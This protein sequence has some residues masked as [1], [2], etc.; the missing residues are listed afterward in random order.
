MLQV[1]FLP[2][3]CLYKI[4]AATKSS[5]DFLLFILDRLRFPFFLLKVTLQIRLVPLL[6]EHSTSNMATVLSYLASY[7]LNMLAEMTKEE[8]TLLFG[9][10]G[11]MDKMSIKL[12]DLK[13]FLADADRRNI[14]DFSVQEWVRELKGALFDATDILDLCQLKAME[15]GKHMDAGCFN[16]L[17][18]C[19]RNPLFAHDICSRIKKLN[20]RLDDIKESSAAF[21]FNL[22]S[23]EDHSRNNTS[24]RSSNRETS[25][26]VNESALVGEKIEEDTRSL[27][28][29]LT[30]DE[31]TTRAHNKIMVFAIVGVGGIGKTTLAQKIF[32][33]YKI[34]HEF[35]KKVWLSVNQDFNATELLKK[36][37]TEAGGDYQA[38]GNTRAALERTLKNAL[39]GHKTLLVVDDVWDHKAW[40]DVLE[41]PLAH[42]LAPGSRVLVTTR[43]YMVARGMNAVEVHRI[44]K[45]KDEDA[46]L[47]LKK[48]VVRNVND[49][50][51]VDMLKD[52][53][54][55]IIEKCDGLPL[56]VKVMGGHLLK[57]NRRRS[58]WEAVLKDLVWSVSQMPEKLYNAIY[59]SYQDLD[60]PLK[61][62]FLYFSL[63]PKSEDFDVDEI[64]GMWISEGIVHGN[65][66]D[67]EKIGRE[68]YDELILRNL[69][70][71][72]TNYADQLVCSMHDVVRSFAQYVARYEA[73]VAGQSSKIDITSKLNAQ[74]FIWLSLENKGSESLEW[75]SLQEQISARTLISVGN[76]IKIKPSDSLVTFSSLRTLHVQDADFDQ[77]S[78]SLVKLKHLRYLSIQY[79]NTSKLPEDIHKM[80]LLQ[81]IDISCCKRLVKLPSSIRKLQNLRYLNLRQSSINS[82]PRGFGGLTSLRILGGFPVHMD[83][84]W[85]SLEELGPLSKLI[86]LSIH[87]LENVSSST[88]ARKTNLGQKVHLRKLMLLCTSKHGNSDEVQKK[89]KQVYDELCPPPSLENLIIDGYFGRLLPRWMTSNAMLSLGS[90]RLLTLE[91]L[92][93]CIELPDVLCQLPCL[94]FLRIIKAPA[95]KRVGPELMQPHCHEHLIAPESLGF[96]F[97]IEVNEC[98]SLRSIYNIPK[99]QKLAIIKCPKLKVLEGVPVLQSLQL[100]DYNMQ[101]LPGYLQDVIPKQLL[102]NCN[103]SLLTCLAAGKSSPEWDKF[104]HIPQ[105]KA[106]AQEVNNNVQR[107]WYVL[108][109]R[110]PFSFKT[111]ISRSAINQGE[112]I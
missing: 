76:N 25:G 93:C 59:L 17:L 66:Y 52:I 106:N 74:R 107:K 50:S 86:V 44:D 35:T 55:G 19:M 80:K 110:S 60:P 101:M 95:I 18:F 39:M 100:D 49:E 94:E 24:S 64:V 72:D 31:K 83:G 3:L 84:D 33:D 13:R 43:H 103:I 67:L 41:T 71:P 57:K 23:E 10:S 2:V 56:A 42:A 8:V 47:L 105:V 6:H 46:W 21:N 16:P 15:R 27:V 14:A 29:L 62:C 51:Q 30:K 45:L 81:Y 58:D 69:I 54:M 87:G 104:R 102:I 85:C 63:L 68:Y 26:E 12:M 48:K 22:G 97:V 40:V 70:E 78:E 36:A 98:S 75:M 38:P 99:L 112:V 79:T 92:P 34:K 77:L 90:L 37:I 20:Q 4:A 61:L 53:G 65:I 9:A 32:N 7:V 96:A 111:N 109:T 5:W 89:I 91:D 82:V 28:E 1:R 73:L 108:Y 88:I 11:Q